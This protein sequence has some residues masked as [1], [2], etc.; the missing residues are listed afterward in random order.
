MRTQETSSR[1]CSKPGCAEPAACTLTYV[2]ADQTVVVG[3]LGVEAEPHGYDLCAEHTE[4]LTAPRG[5]QVVSERSAGPT[6]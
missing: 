5:W 2:Y 4:R 6:S 3:P 1:L